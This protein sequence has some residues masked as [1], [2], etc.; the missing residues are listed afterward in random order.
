M[1][2]LI[3][4]EVLWWGGGMDFLVSSSRGSVGSVKN[5]ADGLLPNARGE[6]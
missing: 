5:L 6:C 1:D 3:A 2:G 4:Y